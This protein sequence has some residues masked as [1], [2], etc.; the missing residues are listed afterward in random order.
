MNSGPGG[1]STIILLA[2]GLRPSSLGPYGNTWFDTHFINRLASESLLFEQC[3]SDT[4]DIQL[5]IRGIL[6]GQHCCGRESRHSELLQRLK[7]TEVQSHLFTS[8]RG[9]VSNIESEFD[10]VV[11]ISLPENEVLCADLTDTCLANYFAAT[12]EQIRELSGPC[13]LVLDCPAFSL[14]WDAPYP[15]RSNLADDEDPTPSDFALPPSLQFN[16]TADDPDRLLDFQTA[17]NAQ[18]TLFDQ[19]VGLLLDEVRQNQW[20]SDGLFCLTSTR[21]FPLGEHGV[22][23]YYRPILHSELLKVPAF[24]RYPENQK[25]FGRSQQLVQPGS[26]YELICQWQ[27]GDGIQ[28]EHPSAFPSIDKD[29]WLAQK[30]TAGVV[31][32]CRLDDLDFCALQTYAWKYISGPAGKLYVKPDD[33]WEYNDASELCPDVFQSIHHELTGALVM[34]ADGVRPEFDLPDALAFGVE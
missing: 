19:M 24:V 22:V 26:L 14:Y 10:R 31:S 11:E 33:I 8:C 13:L 9:R 23:G 2:D 21:A 29:N 25:C 18:V 28:V 20:L 30:R 32:K 4:P 34:L 12:I 1:R 6:G 16:V 5:G 17:Y 3:I 7:E 27:M 15:Y